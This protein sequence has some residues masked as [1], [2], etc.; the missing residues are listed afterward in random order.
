M[1]D[2]LRSWSNPR[3]VRLPIPG[4]SPGLRRV[5]LT[6][7]VESDV[8]ED[9]LLKKLEHLFVGPVEPDKLNRIHARMPHWLRRLEVDTIYGDGDDEG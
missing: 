4:D 9:V 5:E 3:P 6:A 8:D 1:I 2:I 7:I